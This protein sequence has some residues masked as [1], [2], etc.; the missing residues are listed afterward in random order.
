MQNSSFYT[1]LYLQ[2]FIFVFVL[3]LQIAIFP[4]ALDDLPSKLAPTP[5]AQSKWPNLMEQKSFSSSLSL[6]LLAV[7]NPKTTITDKKI[8]PLPLCLHFCT[9]AMQPFPLFS[10]SIKAQTKGIKWMLNG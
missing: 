9:V 8:F 4:A 5:F 2:C 3:F 1:F 10:H 6:S 7:T